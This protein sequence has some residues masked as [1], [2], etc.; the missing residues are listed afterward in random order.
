MNKDKEQLDSL[1]HSFKELELNPAYIY[2][3]NRFNDSCLMNLDDDLQSK[4]ER[5]IAESAVKSFIRDIKMFSNGLPD[6]EIDEDLMLEDEAYVASY[7][8]ILD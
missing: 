1:I 2:M 6:E 7:N 5:Y 4:A 8:G 3:L